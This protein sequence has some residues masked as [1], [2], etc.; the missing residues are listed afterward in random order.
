MDFVAS[1]WMVPMLSLLAFGVV[2]MIGERGKAWTPIG[3]TIVSGVAAIFACCVWVQQWQERSSYTWAEWRWLTMGDWPVQ[4]GYEVQSLTACM[5]VI[6]T[7]IGA[8]VQ[9]YALSYM[10][11]DGRKTTFFAYIS[12]FTCSMCGLV[13]SPNLL[14]L[15]IFWELVGLCSFL[16]IG[17]W[18]TKPAAREAARKA[19]LLTRI[20][21]VGL[22]IGLF[23]L[24]H[25]MPNN[26]LALIDV[27]N[28]VQ[29]GV[30]PEHTV[31][32]VA[33]LLFFG[34]M[35]KS[36]QVPLHTWLPDAMEGPTPISALIHAATMVAAGVFLV[37]RTYDVFLASSTALLIVAIIGAVTAVL[38]AVAALVQRD[39]KRIL[40]YSTVSQ[41]GLMMCTLGMGTQA[42][43]IAALLH[44][45]T[46]ACFKA[47]LFLAAGR[48]IHTVHQQDIEELGGVRNVLP[49]TTGAFA[50]GALALA[51]MVPLS[52]FWSKE[53]LFAVLLQG[54]AVWV[55]T[56]LCVSA[57]TAMYMTRAFVRV[58]L[59]T[60]RQKNVRASR[61]IP[62]GVPLGAL[63]V[64]AIAI[65]W[66]PMFARLGAQ[67]GEG[68]PH[69]PAWL[70]ATS[71]GVVVMGIAV[72]AYVV[73]PRVI[74]ASTRAR[75]PS[76]KKVVPQR[77]FSGT[78]ARVAS[79]LRVA[80]WDWVYR[81]GVVR[82]FQAFSRGMAQ[83]DQTLVRAC[84][85]GI[86]TC[87]VLIGKLASR[88]HVGQLHVYGI[89]SLWGIVALLCF[90]LWKK[91]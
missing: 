6:V 10:R 32:L 8:L 77:R 91:V 50:I 80:V 24:Y 44:L 21:D 9:L 31:T 63:A 1:A 78:G 42:A 65:G 13:L 39:L 2:I 69:T 43:L 64:G 28:A 49:W 25:A 87:T 46:H 48:V 88:A 85:E 40:A 59:G 67:L 66:P 75:Q 82:P 22:L 29:N 84:T 3:S 90:V 60:L 53:A 47:L 58:F 15:F 74:V 16:L 73:R 76:R 45:L 55:T 83:L 62:M 11:D 23:V 54:G 51:G 20:G 72:A 71:L 57:L 5:L 37:S 68:Y 33:L 4:F 79:I 17:F 38:G 35:G 14:Q 7:M 86:G 12:L 61:D 18:F 52:G 30:I 41:L 34:A 89:W 36:G 56:A 26:S 27:H 81:N 70:V 19:F